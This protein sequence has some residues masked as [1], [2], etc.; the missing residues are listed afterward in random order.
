M[1]FFLTAPLFA[2]AA[3]LLLVWQGEAVLTTRWQPHTLSFVHLLVA[4]FM[5]QAM[6]GAL[7]Q[8]VP[9]AAG[10]NVWRP[11][12]VARWTHALAT[13]ATLLLV[14]GF[15]GFS[16]RL[17]EGAAALFVLALGP[18]IAV[19]CAALVRPLAAGATLT[20]LRIALGSLAVTLGLG[21]GLAWSLGHANAWPLMALTD[22]HAG[23]G[24]GGWALI[25]LAGVS[26]Y[27]VPMFQLTPPYPARWARA[28]PWAMLVVLLLL[29]IQTA[30]AVPPSLRWAEWLGAGLAAAFAASTLWLQQRRRRRQSDVTL[31]FFRL[32]M[33]ALVALPV[34]ALVFAAVPA[35]ADAP[36]TMIWLGLLAIV[37]LFVSA[38]NGMLYKIVPFIGWLSLQQGQPR[39]AP[40]MPA[41]ISTAAMR[42]QWHAHCLAG[43]ALL[44]AVW[45]P[46]L[47]RLAGGLF[48]C[49]AAWLGWNLWQAERRRRAFKDR[50]RAD[51]ADRGS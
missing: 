37:G 32:A 17:F 21:V 31:W 45:W 30:L 50:I 33:L 5:L 23:W 24:L 1:R 6:C 9:V 41:L 42:G 13:L 15:L 29:S 22:L 43:A 20:A 27:T 49:S 39:V 19:V 8:F 44:A 35:L 14:G 40:T 28:F 46:P 48:A 51:G 25:L 7:L 47:A 2:V 4:G 34:S 3:G 12:A 26:Y 38:I 36:Q 18:F 16:P 10:G 11:L